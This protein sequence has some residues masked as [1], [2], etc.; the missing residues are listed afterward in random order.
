MSTFFHGLI[1]TTSGTTLDDATQS[2]LRNLEIT[3]ANAIY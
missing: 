2:L 1:I 3:W